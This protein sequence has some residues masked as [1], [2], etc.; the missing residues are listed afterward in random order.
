[1]TDAAQSISSRLR[2]IGVN[3][4]WLKCARSRLRMK[5]LISWGLVVFTVCTFVTSMIYLTATRQQM[6]A[7]EVAAKSLLIPLIV[8][9]GII[10]M[11]LGTGSVTAGLVQE[12]EEGLLDY[13]RMTPMTP[14][15]KILG[16]LFGLPVR[17]Y[18]LFAL[19]LPYVAF[20][21]TVG[22]FDL[23][24]L[25]RFYMVFFTSVWVYHMTGLVIGM[26]WSKPRRAAMVTQGMVI[27][28]YIILP[29]LSNVGLTYFEFLTIRPTLLG[30]VMEELNKMQPGIDRAATSQ[31]PGLGNYEEIGFFGMI[32]SPTQFTLL[33]QGFLLSFAFV[34]VYRKWRDTHD[35]PLSKA[36]AF[37]FYVGTT[38][39]LAGS[40]WPIVGGSQT[41]ERFSHSSPML[42]VLMM[43]FL[44]TSG[45]FM[46]LLIHVVTPTR[47]M[48][49][50]ELR[51]ARKRGERVV[52]RN[53]DGASSLSVTIGM[54]IVTGVATSA[55][56][57]VAAGTDLYFAGRPALNTL[58]WPPLL[59][60]AVFLFVQALRE[61]F[62]AR[63]F[64][65][66]LFLMWVV[67][68]LAAM[69]MFGAAELFV[70]GTYLALL[71][72]PVSLTLMVANIFDQTTTVD[73]VPRFLPPDLDG[74][75][76]TMITLS[77]VG[78]I[79]LAFVM[80]RQLRSW[81]RAWE[82]RENVAADLSSGDPQASVLTRGESPDAIGMMAVPAV[83]HSSIAVQPVA[84]SPPENA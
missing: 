66:V 73:A 57:G 9:Q 32:L 30:M 42:L 39:L 20:A 53:S 3:P 15:A 81:R 29:L 11:L 64:F 61:R 43:L 36:G 38:L 60:V 40:M 4:I 74:H 76:G 6:L 75:V 19:T 41:Y 63:V 78:Y 70:E 13:H 10:L 77:V 26:A 16:Y 24:T 28:L 68:V 45:L 5:Y 12:R 7:P 44:I 31:F 25:A 2:S 58:I 72:A 67:P 8:I 49:M 55:L 54:L 84:G 27:L 22:N 37:L 33:V 50:E 56:A 79:G 69:V 14:V 35:H 46:L 34:V 83:S 48:A 51:R 62:R 80:Q 1:M 47:Y 52:P 71:S 21:V 23:W 65:V 82:S 17:E 59:F 18:C